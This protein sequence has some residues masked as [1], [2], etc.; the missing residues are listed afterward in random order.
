MN[1]GPQVLKPIIFIL[2]CLVCGDIIFSEFHTIGYI[3]EWTDVLSN[4]N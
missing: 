1:S 4:L 3:N 2:G